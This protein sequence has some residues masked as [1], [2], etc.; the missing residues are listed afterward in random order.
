MRTNGDGFTLIELIIVMAVLGIISS[1]F[2]WGLLGQYK[3]AQ[4]QN[5]V[6]TFSS[7]L[8]K[9][10]TT[11]W[12]SGQST[13]VTLLSGGTGYSFRQGSGT[14][15]PVN[16]PDGITATAFPTSAST[17]T[18]TAPFAENSNA[19]GVVFTLSIPN[20]TYTDTVKVFGVT[21]K[22]IR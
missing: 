14:A 22:V 8:Q 4:L 6:T 18:Y 9:A 16:F 3:K 12:R 17:I 11:S 13:T 21:G 5:A 1:L 20:T 2:Y 10:R 19:I 15:V 7:D